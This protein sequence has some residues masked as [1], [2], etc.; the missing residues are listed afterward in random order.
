MEEKKRFSH[1]WSS[2]NSGLL[3]IT[4]AVILVF[5]C[6]N[7]NFL[8]YESIRSIMNSMSFAGIL[9]IG[10]ATLL[11]GGEVDLSSGAI[12]CFSGLVLALMINAGMPWGLAFILTIIFGI[13]C[14][15]INAFFINKLGFM[16]F[17]A[18]LG[19]MS[20]Y[21]GFVSIITHNKNV[22]VVPKGVWI[23]GSTSVFGIIPL[24]F[25]IFA[26]LIIVYGIILNKTNF[27]RCVYM[28]GGNKVAARLCGVKPVKISTLLYANNGMLAAIAGAVL[29]ARMHTASPVAGGSGAVD[30][31]TAAVLGGVAFTGGSGSMVGCFLGILLLNS[32]NAGL[33]AVGFPSYWQ[34]VVR[35][36]LLVLA[37][38]SSNL[39]GRG[40]ER[41]KKLKREK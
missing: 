17:I 8:S 24:P 9:T 25:F 4:I 20:V 29:T 10:M 12:A 19:L 16:H 22:A 35:G 36:C 40:S 11:I 28:C 39:R 5:T 15:L 38:L 21:Q 14:G 2:G 33:T 26:V 30:A 37:L 23:I 7:H 41:N 18:T 32:F 13:L 6:V 34:I 31:I 27:G 1:F 3:L